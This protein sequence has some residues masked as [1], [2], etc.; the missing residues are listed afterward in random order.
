MPQMLDAVVAHTLF[1]GVPV[2]LVVR[3]CFDGSLEPAQ[4]GA[5]DDELLDL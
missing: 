2:A 5:S 3:R 4:D 1:F